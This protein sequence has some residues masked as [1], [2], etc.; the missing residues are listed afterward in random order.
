MEVVWRRLVEKLEK[1][2][3][4]EAVRL[5]LRRF[6]LSRSSSGRWILE[7][8]DPYVRACLQVTFQTQIVQALREEL[9]RDV[10]LDVCVGSGS[11]RRTGRGRPRRFARSTA[12]RDRLSVD[13]GN[14]QAVLAARKIVEAPRDFSPLFVFGPASSGKSHLLRWIDR[15]LRR[16]GRSPLRLEPERLQRAIGFSHKER[17][18]SPL[19]TW[20]DTA[21]A[22]LLEGADQL[23][24]KRQTQRELGFALKRWMERGVPIVCTSRAHP[25]KIHP[26]DPVVETLLLSGFLVHLPP[27]SPGLRAKILQRRLLAGGR[28]VSRDCLEELAPRLGGSLEVQERAVVEWL[29]S[30]KTTDPAASTQRPTT[31]AIVAWVAAHFGLSKNQ[32]YSGGKARSVRLPR[33]LIMYWLVDRQCKSLDE[34]AELFGYRS[35]RSVRDHVG[36]VR[37]GMRHDPDLARWV[38]AL[39]DHLDFIEPPRQQEREA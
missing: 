16:S 20:C 26:L 25:K 36:S 11:S 23:A 22:V 32:I 18:P 28:H 15:R 21:D 13:D 35:R 5:G 7:A 1:R 33:R 24:K 27:Q 2:W 3:G 12:S 9:G 38:A 17:R 4:D 29:Q 8:P 31:D 14:R 37:E 34:V 19:R 30:G 6:R 10:A 39:E